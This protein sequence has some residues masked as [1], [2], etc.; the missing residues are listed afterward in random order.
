MGVDYPYYSET[1]EVEREYGTASFVGNLKTAAN[2]DSVRMIINQVLPLCR[3]L[4]KMDFIGECP[5]Y[6]SKEFENN[7]RVRFTG[8]VEDLRPY[9]EATNM[10]LSPLAYGTGIKTK[11]LEAMAMGMP[12]VTNSIGAEGIPANNNVQ[13]LVS[14]DPSKLAEYVDYLIENPDEGE[15]IGKE[16]REF[17]KKDFQWDHI[18]LQFSRLQL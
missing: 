11:I 1:I 2:V 13:W 7:E 16:A 8:R 12:V 6:L 14:D 9:V 4:K 3:K 18:F 5:D 10:F 17:V 15:R